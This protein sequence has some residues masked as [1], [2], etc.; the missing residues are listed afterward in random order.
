M[1]N[2]N[3]LLKY[4]NV[5]GLVVASGDFISKANKDQGTIRPDAIHI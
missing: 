4:K 3:K 1:M 5:I 2:I